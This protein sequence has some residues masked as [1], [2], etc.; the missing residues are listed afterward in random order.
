MIND[1]IHEILV[2]V[3]LNKYSFE[4]IGGASYPET[5]LICVFFFF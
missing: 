5:P 2:N 1:I 4:D 3:G